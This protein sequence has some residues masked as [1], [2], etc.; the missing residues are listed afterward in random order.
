MDEQEHRD[1]ITETTEW[2][3]GAMV[4]TLLKPENLQKPHWRT[5]T[6]LQLMDKLTDNVNNFLKESDAQKELKQLINIANY[7]MMLADKIRQ[8]YFDQEK[9]FELG[10]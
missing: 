1:T 3:T 9:A 7:S 10:G 6:D 5:D 8:D 4:D 2:F